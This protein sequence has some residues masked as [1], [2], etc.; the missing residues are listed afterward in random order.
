MYF[1]LLSILLFFCVSNVVVFGQINLDKSNSPTNT[2]D[3]MIVDQFTVANGFPVSTFGNMYQ[4]SKGY[5]WLTS[6]EGI[7][8]FDGFKCDIFNTE[9]TAIFTE[10]SFF[11]IVGDRQGRVYFNSTKDIFV[12]ENGKIEKVIVQTEKEKQMITMAIDV[13]DR[14][15]VASPKELFYIENKQK[16]IFKQSESTRLKVANDP[17]GNIFFIEDKQIFSYS[18]GE[19]TI[20]LT[21]KDL[22]KSDIG[23]IKSYKDGTLWISTDR[24]LYYFDGQKIHREIHQ[25][26][27][28]GWQILP[29]T[30]T[31]VW[32]TFYDQIYR[33]IGNQYHRVI[34]S[35][36]KSPNYSIF[37]DRE[38]NIWIIAHR[39]GLIRL[40]KRKVN[41]YPS[42]YV[43]NTV[44]E[45]DKQL[46]RAGENGIIE[47]FEDQ[48]WK[49]L[50]TKIQK[51][52][53]I[54]NIRQDKDGKI[55]ISAYPSLLSIDNK[56]Q[57]LYFAEKSFR[58]SFRDKK[59]RLWLSNYPNE[60]F[61]MNN[62]QLE[63]VQR[64]KS[65]IMA[66]KDDQ[67]GNLW[68]A[69]AGNGVFVLKDGLI[70]KHYDDQNGLRSHIVFNIYIDNQNVVWL[71]CN[72]GL[73]RIENEKITNF[74]TKDGLAND[75][76]YDIIEDDQGVFW[77]PFAKGLAT[78]SRKMLNDFAQKKIQK[79]VSKVYDQRDGVF[80]NGFT[81]TAYSA[82]GT[83][84]KMWFPAID[85]VC[86]VDQKQ[87]STDSTLLPVHLEH[88]IVENDTLNLQENI[89]IEAGKK[90]FHFQFTAICMYAPQSVR[91]KYRLGGF[92]TEWTENDYQKREA[93]YTNLQAGKYI[94]KVLACNSEGIW[95]EI[96]VTLPFEIKAFW[97]ETWAARIFAML[98]LWFLIIFFYQIRVKQ[99]KKRQ[100][101]LEKIVAERTTEIS[102]QKDEIQMQAIHLQE[103][104]HIKDRM[105]SIISHDLR[106]PLAQ[107]ESILF[108]L[109]TGSMSQA[110]LQ[111]LMPLINQNMRYTS[112]LTNNLLFWAK[113]Q[114]K[115][116][117]P[118]KEEFDLYE[119]VE[120]KCNWFEKEVKKKEIVLNN[121]VSPN[122]IIKTDQNLVDMLLRN[123]VGNAI[124]F[125]KKG[126]NIRIKSKIIDKNI[127]ISVIDAGVGISPENL[128]KIFGNKNFSTKGTNDEQGT[129]LGLVFCKELLEKYGGQIW[130]ESEQ[131]KGSNFTFVLP[132]L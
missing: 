113:T 128:K 121:H 14:L 50:V 27:Q 103:L 33:K 94:F 129:G 32:I 53:R 123:L 43:I 38:K 78:V 100:I 16:H 71:A 88:F 39:R 101:L 118:K 36:F 20:I 76:V 108:L 77:M 34:H 63:L 18:K 35:L 13:Q 24:G 131:N 109:E 7:I 116:I 11:E 51:G 55:W 15:W 73:S 6:Y 61:M 107:L 5:I 125:S 3:D 28:G 26:S 75:Q 31:G 127:N 22:P 58:L 126:E 98:F 81:P 66:M 45:N 85:G 62:D 46:I 82:K 124:K 69:T 99:L 12:Y 114:I 21:E 105:F 25:N 67:Q 17:Q 68:V 52:A 56:E 97:Y 93:I 90:H 115:G 92:D 4:D 117:E 111:D 86:M 23:S 64:F 57:K 54:R 29:N 2:L 44:L 80:S 74:N 9:N 84:G 10:N 59:K 95:N 72:G 89:V 122:T 1:L 91:F 104:N 8:R 42:D 106:S 37:E 30:T 110:D 49:K 40:K 87:I 132:I 41:Y 65:S 48:K 47:S 83:N 102:A 19:L 120:S 130:V 79:I 60:L 96:G 119:L 112:D 70:Q